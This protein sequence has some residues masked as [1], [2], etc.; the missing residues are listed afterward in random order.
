[1]PVKSCKSMPEHTCSD[2]V[3]ICNKIDFPP[4][5]KLESECWLW[6]G[7]LTKGGYAVSSLSGTGIRVHRF[8][9]AY[10]YGDEIEKLAC[11]KHSGNRHCVNPHHLY[12]GTDL[13]NVNDR[14]RD[15]NHVDV[16][17]EKH[18]S[19]K[20]NEK[21]VLEIRSK[22]EFRKHTQK[23][24]ALEYGVTRAAICD[25]VIRRSWKHI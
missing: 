20:L 16:R 8:M 19:V 18:P 9:C 25:V 12:W 4:D 3:R 24:L 7:G 5:D 13:D 6:K 15:G 23:Q 17:G 1:M 10:S 14:D 11:H 2:W 21:Q 22:Y